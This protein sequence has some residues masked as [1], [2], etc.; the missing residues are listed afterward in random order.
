MPRIATANADGFHAI[1]DPTRRAILDPA[2]LADIGM[3]YEILP[4]MT[5]VY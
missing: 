5:A 4:M 1:E 2:M 3:R